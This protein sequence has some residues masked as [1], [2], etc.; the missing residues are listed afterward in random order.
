M[1]LLFGGEKSGVTTHNKYLIS[2]VNMDGSYW[3]KFQALDER[4]ICPDVRS[5]TKGSWLQDLEKLSVSSTD[6][7]SKKKVW[8]SSLRQT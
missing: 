7:C 1:H 5:V 6:V 2:V 3:C 4:V 8:Q